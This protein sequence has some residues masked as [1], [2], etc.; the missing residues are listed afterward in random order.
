MER[1]GTE[2]SPAGL[3]HTTAGGYE[4]CSWDGL[5]QSLLLHWLWLLRVCCNLASASWLRRLL[6]SASFLGVALCCPSVSLAL[7]SSSML[8][9]S[10][11]MLVGT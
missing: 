11:E 4:I 5:L 6:S 8:A 10:N 1:A 9:G 3:S 2:A 7:A